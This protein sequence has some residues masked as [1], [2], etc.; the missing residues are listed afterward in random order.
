VVGLRLARRPARPRTGTTTIRRPPTSLE[1]ARRSAAHRRRRPTRE[2][3]QAGSWRWTRPTH[4]WRCAARRVRPATPDPSPSALCAAARPSFAADLRL[5]VDDTVIDGHSATARRGC[6][7]VRPR[8]R[9]RQALASRRP[10]RAFGA[11][12]DPGTRGAG[13]AT[14]PSI[15]V[16]RLVHEG[17]LWGA[18][19]RLLADDDRAL[20]RARSEPATGDLAQAKTN[21]TRAARLRCRPPA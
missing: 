12:N 3:L 15:C 21:L 10:S 8:V 17:A 16:R 2:A 19:R 4:A 14:D 9:C 11:V 20:V 1:R 13:R 18:S 7:P 5:T 6:R